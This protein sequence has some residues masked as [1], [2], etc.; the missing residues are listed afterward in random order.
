MISASQ[1]AQLW[2][3]HAA[4]LRL[5]A[6]VRSDLADDCVQEAFVRLSQQPA[7]PN[8]PL[9]WLVRVVRNCALVEIRSE[10]RRK[11]R[12]EHWQQNAGPW[13]TSHSGSIDKPSPEEAEQALR[14]LAPDLRELVVAVIWT[15]MTFRQ[16]AGAFDIPTATAHRRFREAIEELRRL[17]LSQQTTIQTDDSSEARIKAEQD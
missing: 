8:D 4:G 13:L 3:Q 11:A 5:L 16:V 1:L 10:K 15:G 12:E 7:L 6:R 9:A 14:H 2:T 17:L